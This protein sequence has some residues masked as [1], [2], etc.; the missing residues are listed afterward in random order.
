M[1]PRIFIGSS[2]EGADIARA[3]EVHLN[4]VCQ[5]MLWQSNVFE[6]SAT[7]IESLEKALD[8]VEFAVLVVTPDDL[9]V[10]RAETSN[11][12]RDNVVFE[13]GLFMGRLSRKRVFVVCDPQNVQLPTDLLGLSLA[14]YDSNW[15]DLIPAT[16]VAATKIL[17]A[18]RQAP[19]L[20]PSRPAT[21]PGNIL[22]DQDALFNAIVG[23]PT[24]GSEIIIQTADTHW[25]WKIFLTLAPWRLN[26]ARVSVFAPP[27]RQGGLARRQAAAQRTLLQ[28]IGVTF[29]ETQDLSVSGFF[30]RTPYPEDDI[31]IVLNEGMGQAVPLAVK[32]EG[33]AHASA[34]EALQKLLPELS[35]PPAS[36]HSPSLVPQ[37]IA[38]VYDRLRVGVS[39]YTSPRIEMELTTIKTNQL[40]LMS[41][42]ARSY[43]Y[44]QIDNLLNSYHAIGQQPFTALA[45]TL[46]SGEKSIV[47]P[48]VVEEHP[49]GPVVIE[50]TTR[51]AY[52]YFNNIGDY[53][54]I[55][56]RG[57]SH[58][59][60]GRPI[61]IKSV[62]I[63][64]R[65][66]SQ[67]ERTEEFHYSLFR[68][69]ER[70]VHPY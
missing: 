47:T 11:V 7:F 58:D 24:A 16:S 34:V 51:A 50:G 8:E 65:S 41:P 63:T 68:L 60:P 6:V 49:E 43:K 25:V 36:L 20:A 42:Y 32:Y 22:L 52:C 56:V 61:D 4:V 30:L 17:F 15:N 12:P 62:T 2:T 21:S 39:Q 5:C 53:H 59:L 23:W 48:P 35:A 64:E 28:E 57:V 31:V 13:L 18:I 27:I 14:E 3:I 26:G 55:R 9:R 67:S 38:E 66:L 44:K 46:E 1:K 19:R 69:I 45:V 29:N 33:R 54:C 37:E 10:K 40:L 70:A